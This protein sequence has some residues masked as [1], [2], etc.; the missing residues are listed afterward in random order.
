[1]AALTRKFKKIFGKD[2][3]NNGVFGSAA[4]LDPQ[5]STDPAVIESLDAFLNGWSDATE[6]GLRLPTLE[7]LQGL[8]YDT[9]YHLAY[10]YQNGM[11]VYNSETTY[12]IDN[13]VREDSTG[14]IWKS[15]I[16]DNTGNSLVEGSNWTLLANLIYTPA[17]AALLASNNLSDLTSTSTAR[18]N[19]GLGTAALLDTG[20]ST[21][22]IPVIGTQSATTSTAGLASLATS[23]EVRTGTDANKIITPN[24]LAGAMVNSKATS[25][26]TYLANGL[27]FQWGT[28][29][30][31]SGSDVA[32]DA[33]TVV[34]P[35]T[36]P[37]AV[38][39]VVCGQLASD[40]R[41]AIYQVYGITTSQFR[42][43]ANAM[44][45]GGSGTITPRWIAIGY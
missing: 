6:G 23:T 30:A 45:T 24:A 22:N 36:F 21:G 16:D 19:L 14:K 2:S 26:Y 37:N 33:Q 32:S 25:G 8:K 7:D 31:Q 20:T 12:Y 29:S 44:N 27:I 38:F 35:I 34:F 41:D 10:I 40:N 9:D 28:G 13:L 43:F 5:T 18:T 39:S 1:M 17:S 4:A 15:L 11:Q 3:S 42:A